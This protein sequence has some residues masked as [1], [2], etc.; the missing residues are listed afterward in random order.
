MNLAMDANGLIL[1]ANY[2]YPNLQ[3]TVNFKC[4]SDSSIS[5]DIIIVSID[6]YN[7]WPYLTSNNIIVLS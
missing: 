5:L 7:L 3:C 4:I 2:P 6:P 1:T